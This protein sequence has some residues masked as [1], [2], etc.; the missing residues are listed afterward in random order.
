M[1]RLILSAAMVMVAVAALAQK[2]KIKITTEYGNIVVMLY[3]NTPLNTSNMVKVAKDHGY[4]STL[5]HR[6]IPQFMIQGGDP[7]SKNAKPGQMLGNGGLKYT[8]PAEIND[9]YYHKRGALGVA[10]DGNPQKA[11]SASQF[12][13]VVGKKATDEEL[14]RISAQ[15]GRKFSA[16]QREVYK[17]IGGTPHLDGNYT[18][19]GEVT[20][21][22]DIVDKI[23]LEPRDR[24]DRPNKD[25]R[26]LSGRVMKKKHRFLFF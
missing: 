13:L 3:D 12:Y 10:R 25:I 5:F 11:G 9:E 17:T 24:S 1:K 2:Q 14:D 22:M 16:E 21:G 19:F 23:A 26:M 15:T 18:V 6:V 7:D 4:D 8:V 20:E